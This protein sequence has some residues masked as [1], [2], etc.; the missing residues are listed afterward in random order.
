MNRILIR[1]LILSIIW[2]AVVIAL[3]ATHHAEYAAT[4]MPGILALW[5][6]NGRACMHH[7]LDRVEGK[8]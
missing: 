5:L 7:S 3:I 4:L 8:P 1:N 2:L 6:H